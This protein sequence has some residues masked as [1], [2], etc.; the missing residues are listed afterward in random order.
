MAVDNFYSSID[1]ESPFEGSVWGAEDRE[2]LDL[3]S[4]VKVEGRW[5][6]L[7]AGDGRYNE[8][9]LRQCDQVT[10]CDIDKRAL[11]RLE[12]RT[13]EEILGKLKTDVLDITGRFP[14][15]DD[16]YSGLLC[17]GTLATFD[18]DKVQHLADEMC[19]VVKPGGIVLF[20]FETD[21]TREL[22][23]GG[24]YKIPG[25]AEYTLDQAMNFVQELFKGRDFSVSVSTVNGAEVNLG[26]L[27]YTLNCKYLLVKVVV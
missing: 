13:P 1:Y 21:V 17:T 8:Y 26:G 23:T 5:L 22:R 20:D 4:S 19:R 7:A 25:I 16:C 27:T 2:V 10:A 14:Y 11:I 12:K 24:E 18:R 15:E 9:L 6:N 3:L